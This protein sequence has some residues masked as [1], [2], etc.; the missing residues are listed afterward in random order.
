MQNNDSPDNKP[1]IEVPP[2]PSEFTR[3]QHFYFIEETSGLDGCMEASAKRGLKFLRADR[4]PQGIE[5]FIVQG[6]DGKP[7]IRMPGRNEVTRL[8]VVNRWL[9]KTMAPRKTV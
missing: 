2:P 9:V 8:P 4:L 3:G 5:N 1:T 7:R 6:K